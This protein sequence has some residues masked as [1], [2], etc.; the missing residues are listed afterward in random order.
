ME[1]LDVK[2]M[3]RN[4]KLA[5][6]I[7]EMNFGEFRRIL[8]YK[9]K[10]YGR[11]LVFVNRFFPS[12]KKCGHCEYINKNLKLSDRR[13]VCPICGNVIERDYNAAMNILNEGIRIIGLSSP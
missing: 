8:E 3:L 7:Q 4:H 13:W 6:S 11:D 5:E 12:S 10:W 9:A 1:D 2:G